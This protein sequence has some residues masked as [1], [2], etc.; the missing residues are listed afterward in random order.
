MQSKKQRESSIVPDD[1]S[2]EA[3][4]DAVINFIV[5]HKLDPAPF[6]TPEFSAI[7]SAVKEA[8]Y[9]SIF[10]SAARCELALADTSTPGELAEPALAET[11]RKHIPDTFLIDAALFCGRHARGGRPHGVT[12]RRRPALMGAGVKGQQAVHLAYCQEQDAGLEPATSP[13]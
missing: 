10:G 1:S 6:E 3:V 5:T 12:D 7:T 9:E 8:T 11:P 4:S 13:K 2:G